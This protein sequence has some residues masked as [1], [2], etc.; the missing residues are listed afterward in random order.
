LSTSTR[1]AHAHLQAAL[2]AAQLR[3][4]RNQ[5]LLQGLGE[6]AARLHPEPLL[7]RIERGLALGVA[8]LVKRSVAVAD[9]LAR[10]RA[11]DATLA[12]RI[13][14]SMPM[15]ASRMLLPPNCP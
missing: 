7:L 15:L 6:C 8:Q 12:D 9:R 3:L 14:N 13:V 1:S 11:H 2:R 5:C 4:D 10:A